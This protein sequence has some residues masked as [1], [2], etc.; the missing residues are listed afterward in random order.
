MTEHKRYMLYDD[1]VWR[2]LDTRFA[3][4]T[5]T[6]RLEIA[7]EDLTRFLFDQ[8][9]SLARKNDPRFSYEN[10]AYLLFELKKTRPEKCQLDDLK[11]AT[12]AQGFSWETAE[13]AYK[14]LSA[15]VRDELETTPEGKSRLGAYP[16]FIDQVIRANGQPIRIVTLNH[17][18]RIEEA[19][20][21]SGVQDA[22]LGFTTDETTPSR[23]FIFSKERLA[24][25]A[26]AKLLKLHGSIDWYWR[27]APDQQIVRLSPQELGD[28]E[29]IWE[30]ALFLSGTLNKPHQY[31]FLH[32]PAL[33]EEFEKQLEQ[34]RR[35][36]VSGYGFGDGGVNERFERWLEAQPEHRMLIVD[37][38]PAGLREKLTA[39]HQDQTL[40]RLE[41]IPLSFDDLVSSGKEMERVR[42]FAEGR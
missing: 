27:Y 39:M 20:A 22:N 40:R 11:K 35:I 18:T 33:F 23:S 5:T 31:K 32:Y 14:R 38:N 16:A 42:R 15:I 19:M 28:S 26:P 41:F 4:I 30:V 10:V 8:L 3:P 29:G 37:P 1:E 36:V 2:G 25:P 21:A 34:T 9:G 6:K 17:D 13:S 24:E 7:A 12:D